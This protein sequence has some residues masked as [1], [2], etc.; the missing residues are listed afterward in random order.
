[1]TSKKISPLARFDR[2]T[3]ALESEKI[4]RNKKRNNT[5]KMFRL[6]VQYTP[7][8]LVLS[9]MGWFMSGISRRLDGRMSNLSGKP[10]LWERPANKG[11]VQ[12]NHCS[13]FK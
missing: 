1:M 4:R 10:T 12:I 8:T 2:A 11:K 9:G 13:T 7:R 3:Y 5:I 6:A